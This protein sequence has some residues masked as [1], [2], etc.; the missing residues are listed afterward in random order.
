MAWWKTG[1]PGDKIVC[2][3]DRPLRWPV[4]PLTKGRVYTVNQIKE[5]RFMV[6]PDTYDV[7][8]GVFIAEDNG[9]QAAYAPWRFRPVRK[10]RTETGMAMLRR[11]LLTERAREG[12]LL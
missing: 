7:C 12:E 1:Q 8:I 2:V 11:C 3:D 5:Q 9:A 4:F 10:A 6:G